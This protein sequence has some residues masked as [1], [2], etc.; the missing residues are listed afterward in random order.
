[1]PYSDETYN[2]RIELDTK[3][4]SLSAEQI[5]KM[6]G[7]LQAL[8]RA[9][10][11][12]PVS[13]LYVTV[14]HHPRSGDFHVKLALVL[15]GRTLFT[16]ERHRDSY[17]A[18]KQCVDKLLRKVI[19]YKQDLDNA[20]ERSKQIKGT[21]QEIIPTQIPD[22][23]DLR[24]AVDEGDYARF[25][26]GMLMYEE[27]VR[28]RIGRWVQ[29]DPELEALI[30]ERLQLADIVED[31]FLTAFERYHAKPNQ[32]L[33]GDWLEELISVVLRALAADPDGELENVSMVRTAREAEA[34]QSADSSQHTP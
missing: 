10:Q 4:C 34:E 21:H 8:H 15:P 1:M 29:R 11:S 2:L 22:H 24:R 5:S 19:A 6:E 14:I 25:R 28:K 7:A 20:S 3:H 16:G 9:T 18:Y 17:A 33:P 27:P 30:G 12:F 13:D 26:N 31:V 23:D 32:M